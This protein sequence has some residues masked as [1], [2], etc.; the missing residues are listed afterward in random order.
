MTEKVKNIVSFLGR[1]ALSAG[2]LAWIFSFVNWREMFGVMKGADVGFLLW[3]A[4][5]HFLIQGIVLVRWYLFMN[6]LKLEVSA[7]MVCRYYFIGLFCN[8]F[9]PTAIGGD[10]VKAIGLSRRAGQKPKVFASVVL[11]RLSGFAGI[12]VVAALAYVFGSKLINEPSMIIPIAVLTVL[13]LAVGGMLFSQP[14]Y[15]FFGGLF[16]AV[17]R[18]HKGI[19]QMHEDVLLMRGKKRTGLACVMLSCL[20]QALS[21]YL[22]YLL[23]LALHQQVHFMPFLVFTPI[24]AVITFLPSIGGLGVREVGWV[25]FLAKIGLAQG[26]AVSLSL[27]SFFYIIITGLIGGLIY[28]TTVPS[29][30]VQCDETDPGAGSAV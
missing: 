12:V 27:L 25:Y 10:L 30:R 18:V 20:V 15:R 19:L 1:L 14:V 5:V 9:L 16:R 26:V 4:A 3:A 21:A 8:L 22:F 7:G 24:V 29:G 28:V 6:A 11:D 13:S 17:P 23:A 2:L